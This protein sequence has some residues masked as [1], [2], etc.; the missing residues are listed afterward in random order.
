MLVNKRGINYWPQR[1]K[2]FNWTLCPC[3]GDEFHS[4]FIAVRP[5]SFL[6]LGAKSHKL[7]FIS[8]FSVASIEKNCVA[9]TVTHWSVKQRMHAVYPGAGWHIKACKSGK[10][11]RVSAAG[12]FRRGL[13]WSLIPIAYQEQFLWWTNTQAHSVIA[14][15]KRPDLNQPKTNSYVHDNGSSDQTCSLT[16]II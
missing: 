9:F 4:H 16:H 5:Q 10:E 15:G 3:A 6:V 14:W 2:D 8:I 7:L 12:Q 1:Q 13:W 11:C